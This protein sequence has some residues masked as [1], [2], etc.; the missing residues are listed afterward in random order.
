MCSGTDCNTDVVVTNRP[1]GTT[2]QNKQFSS[3]ELFVI[4][5]IILSF[6]MH[7]LRHTPHSGCKGF[8]GLGIRRGL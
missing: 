2:L 6:D 1:Q 5:F 7:L 4:V 3:T 8:I